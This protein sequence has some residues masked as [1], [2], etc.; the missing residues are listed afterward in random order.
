MTMPLE[1]P[2]CGYASDPDVPKPECRRC[3]YE[4][5]SD[6][7]ANRAK[8]FLPNRRRPLPDDYEPQWDPRER[9]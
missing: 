2:S 4:D 8:P 1:C 5:Y 9:D 6:W 3:G 7:D